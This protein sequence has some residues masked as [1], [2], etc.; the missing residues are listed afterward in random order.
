[1]NKFKPSK[2]DLVFEE[3]IKELQKLKGRGKEFNFGTSSTAKGSTE[4]TLEFEY[5]GYTA[6]VEL[7]TI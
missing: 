3:L 6:K 5:E 2:K 4:H 7:K 1:M